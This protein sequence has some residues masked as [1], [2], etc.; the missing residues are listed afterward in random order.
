M[1]DELLTETL[2]QLFS[3]HCG[4]A[5][6]QRAE[7]DGWLDGCWDK[8]TESGLAWV[9]IAE[10]VGGSGGDLLDA[11][12]LVR[13]AGAHAVPLPL[14]E[15]AMLGGW[16]AERGSIQIGDGPVSVAIP[17]RGDR[18][19][20]DGLRLSGRL[21]RVPW[22][23]RV[24]AVLAVANSR[25]GDRI[26]GFDPRACALT[27][28]RNLA[29]EPRDALLLDGVVVAADDVGD[30][31]DGAALELQIRGAL[32]RALMIAGAAESVAEMTARYASDR[33]QFGRP[34]I[35]FQ[36][37]AHRLVQLT[38]EAEAAGLAAEVAARRFAQLGG[39]LAADLPDAAFDVAV[40]K[41]A[42]ARS[43]ANVAA[44]SHQVHG[45]IGMTQEFAL[46]HFTR[47]IWAWSHEWGTER[48][49]CRTIGRALVD[50]GAPRLWPRMTTGLVETTSR[51]QPSATA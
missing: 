14:A 2:S 47:R 27:P 41:A 8:L 42:T 50:G 37:I 48:D 28:G 49:W 40:A 36:A 19:E 46:H 26:V 32:S 9:G 12:V 23:S 45:A 38:S 31:P 29:G 20:L 51:R 34:I 7:T 16:L 10:A 6:R 4:P 15:G 3:K 25:R 22:G 17:R 24:C 33:H 43:A 18:L 30:A 21:A 39:T 1:G 13:Q 44:H 11:A 35:A 5:E